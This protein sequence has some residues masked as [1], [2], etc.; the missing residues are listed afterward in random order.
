MQAAD[1]DYS[2]ERFILP[3]I[4]LKKDDPGKMGADTIDRAIFAAQLV[5][6]GLPLSAED[7]AAL[8]VYVKFASASHQFST[9]SPPYPTDASASMFGQM[10]EK[11]ADDVGRPTGDEERT[12]VATYEPNHF[13][14]AEAVGTDHIRVEFHSHPLEYIAERSTMWHCDVRPPFPLR[15]PLTLPPQGVD[16]EGGCL[17]GHVKGI[18]DYYPGVPVFDCIV[19]SHPSFL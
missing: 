16:V 1:F 3:I 14:N 2:G 18:F 8:D 10:A 7:S 17:S 19:R 13:P 12:V 6:R 5:I 4:L 11:E 15:S 9:L